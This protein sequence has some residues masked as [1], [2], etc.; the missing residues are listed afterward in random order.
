M[1]TINKA[2]VIVHKPT[3]A[4]YILALVTGVICSAMWTLWFVI[5]PLARGQ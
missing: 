3:K 2:T 4:V 1:F 5:N